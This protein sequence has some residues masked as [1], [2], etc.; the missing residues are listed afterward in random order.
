LF[1]RLLLLNFIK[2]FFLVD[3]LLN[4]G[5]D[6]MDGIK[7]KSDFGYMLLSDVEVVDGFG[8]VLVGKLHK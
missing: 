6:F 7:V 2:L 1:F 8:Q 5:H 4:F 3:F